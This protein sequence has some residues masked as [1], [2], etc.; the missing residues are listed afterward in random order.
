ME[1]Q[2]VRY[3]LAVAKTLNFTRA[4]EQCNVT[5]PALTRAIKQLED[6]LGGELIRREGR[7]SHLSELGQRMLPLLTQCYESALGAKALAAKVRCGDLA[8]LAIGVSRTLDLDLLLAAL[9]ELQRS[10]PGVQL[11]LRRGTG[12]Q[13]AEWLKSGEI[14][15]AFAGPLGES[16]DRLDCW[17]MF[18]EAFDLVVAPDHDFAMRNELDL[19]VELIGR[20][21]LLVH[22]DNDTPELSAVNLEAVGIRLNDAHQV[23]CNRDL[24][25]MLAAR[26][27]VAILPASALRSAHLRHLHCSALDLRR[28]VAVYSIAGRGRSREAN[29]LLNL[30]R[31]ADW[32]P[33][34]AA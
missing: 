3:F 5:Q 33:R 34:L 12:A 11:K 17:P 10:F 7:L 15:L 21:R 31:A 6:E 13:L 29:A 23:D 28:T 19:D 2:Q 22:A 4:A 32:S 9:G 25:I 1:M 16:W 14:E 20:E 18:T 27:G 26:L 30:V 24:E 8:S